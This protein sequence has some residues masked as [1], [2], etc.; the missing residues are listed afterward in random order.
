MVERAYPRAVRS[1]ARRAWQVSIRPDARRLACTAPGCPAATGV[2]ITGRPAQQAALDHLAAHAQHEPLDEHLRTCRCHAHSC[3]W[4][5][6]H[7]GCTGPIQLTVFRQHHGRSWHLA[8]TCTGCARSIPHAAQVPDTPDHTAASDRPLRRSA[9]NHSGDPGV[10]T[11]APLQALLRY[12]AAALG[13][14]VPPAG[15]LLAL[16][17]LLR[18]DAHGHTLVPTG[19]LRAL[20]LA[21]QREALTRAL[22]R[23]KWLH[24]STD[25]TYQTDAARSGLA[26]RLADPA[27]S[28]ALAELTGRER[29]ALC[30]T[31]LRVLTQPRLQ[32]LDSGSRLAALCQ[33]AESEPHVPAATLQGTALEHA[34]TLPVSS[35]PQ[36]LVGAGRFPTWTH[37][38]YDRALC[39]RGR[40]K[41]GSASDTAEHK[42]YPLSSKDTP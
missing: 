35:H 1:A 26:G 17:C 42:G 30:D 13:P 23:E 36:A 14:Q 32:A 4:H 40:H 29:R 3:T 39:C 6:R 7:R 41:T 18:A 28:P 38:P 24:D 27:A 9:E 33:A 11:H 15:Q 31:A 21:D 37:Q 25:H 19:L 16:L 8:D 2:D 22:T 5:P 20:R 34:C 12:L 10:P